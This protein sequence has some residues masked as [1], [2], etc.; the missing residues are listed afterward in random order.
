M[1]PEMSTSLQSAADAAKTH[2]AP[3]AN[4]SILLGFDKGNTKNATDVYCSRRP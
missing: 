1:A 3:D 2:D 4:E